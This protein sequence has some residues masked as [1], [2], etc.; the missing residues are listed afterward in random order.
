MCTSKGP[1]L[2]K[3]YRGRP[4]NPTFSLVP[5][6]VSGLNWIRVAPNLINCVN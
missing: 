2:C 5:G 1:F 3:C 6:L 4:F